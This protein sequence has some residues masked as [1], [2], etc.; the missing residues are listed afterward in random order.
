LPALLHKKLKEA[1]PISRIFLWTLLGVFNVFLWYLLLAFHWEIS[2]RAREIYYFGTQLFPVNA[3]GISLPVI[4]TAC[5]LLTVVS[6]GAI[7]R[8]RS[9]SVARE[10][11]RMLLFQILDGLEMGVVVLDDRDQLTMANDSAR[12]LLPE[13]PRGKDSHDILDV[14]QNRPELCEIVKAATRQGAYAQGLEHDLGAKEDPWP[15]RVTTLP[16]KDPHKRTTGT[17]LLVND[18]RDIVRMERQMRTAERLSAL[19]T[20]AAAMAHEIRN[21]LE[22]MDLNL[23]LLER[24]LTASQPSGAEGDKTGKYVR[25]LESEISRL[26]SIVE[27]FLSFARPSSSPTAE[28]HLDVVLRQIVDLLSNQA[29]S[30]KVNLSLVTGCR[31]VVLGSEDLIKQAFLNLVI[32]SLEAM[33][34]GGVVRIHTEALLQSGIPNKNLAVVRIQDTGVG[35]TPEQLTRVFDPFFTTRPRG[36]GLGLTIVHRVIHEHGGRIHVTSVPGEGTTFTVEMPLYS[37]AGGNLS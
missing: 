36:T 32:N 12:R 3:Q 4:Y 26:A 11:I 34:N 14:L 35:I 37:A 1:P 17:L 6:A 9:N 29:H 5:G 7:L 27:N 13:I 22:A 33:P 31:P 30:R 20:L 15:V 21:P 18:V 2:M 23:A 16:L 19:G 8:D 25:I 28:V 24:H 10:R